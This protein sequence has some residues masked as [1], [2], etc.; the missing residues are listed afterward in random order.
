M[1]NKHTSWKTHPET[2]S[3]GC[4]VIAVIIDPWAR[5]TTIGFWFWTDLTAHTVC[6][7]TAVVPPRAHAVI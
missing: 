6:W 3:G 1:V 4:A 7:A 2:Y 5:A